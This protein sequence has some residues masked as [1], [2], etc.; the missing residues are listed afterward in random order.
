MSFGVVVL[1]AVNAACLLA[2]F[3]MLH[4]IEQR[5]VVLERRRGTRPRTRK[6]VSRR[7]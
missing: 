1:L 3:V 6:R 2:L 5:L 7:G 4:R